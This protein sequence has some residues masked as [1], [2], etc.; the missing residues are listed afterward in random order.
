MHWTSRALLATLLLFQSITPARALW[1]SEFLADNQTGIRDAEGDRSDWLEIENPSAVAVSMDGWFLTDDANQ[2]QKWRF[3]A[4]TLA[5]GGRLLVFASGKDKRRP[6]FELHTNFQLSSNGEYLALV[7]PD[8]V[9]VEHAYAPSYPPQQPDISYGL[10]S[11]REPIILFSTNTPSFWKIPRAE[12]DRPLDWNQPGINLVSWNQGT[13]ALGFDTTPWTNA[14]GTN[15]ARGRSA[16]QSSTLSPFSAFLAVDGRLT[17]FTQTASGTGSNAYWEVTMASPFLIDSVVVRNRQDCCKSRLRDIQIS[18]RNTVGNVVVYESALLNPENILG[19]PDQITLELSEELLGRVAGNRIRITRVRDPDLSGGGVSGDD[20]EVLSM[21]EVEVYGRPFG[22]SLA[23]LIRTDLAASMS[24]AASSCLVRVPFDDPWKG[25]RTWEELRLKVRYNDGFVAYLNGVEVARL[26]APDDLAWNSAARTNRSKA[27][28]FNFD[29]LDLSP[30]A[31]L[32]RPTGNVL[33]FQALSSGLQDTE[34]ILQPVLQGTAARRDPGRYLQDPTP[35]T[36]NSSGSMGVTDLV[37]FSVERGF[38]T[39]PVDVVLSTTTDGAVIRY[40]LD[41]SDPEGEA[42]LVYT[43]PI[44]LTKTTP[45]RAISVKNG[46]RS[47]PSVTH[48]YFFLEDIVKQTPQTTLA[49]GFPTTWGGVTPDYGMDPRVIGGSTPDLFGGKYAA[50]IRDDLRSLPT[51]AL[52]VNVDDLFGANGIYSRSDAGGDAFE[53]DVSAEMIQTNGATAFQ[54]NAGLRVQGGAFRS[55]GL[56]KKH[57]LRLLFNGAHGPSKL[58]YPVFGPDA[59]N[60]FDTITLRAN[61]N[62][63]YSWGDAATQPLYIRDAFGRET[64]LEINGAASH[65]Q[66]VHLYL[67]SLYWGLYDM[68]ERPDSTFSAANFGGEREEWDSL[69]SGTPTEGDTRAW[70]ILNRLA[71]NTLVNNTNYFRLQGRDPDGTINSS[72]TNY[73]D[74]PNMIDYMIVNLWMGN[75]D[76]P[77]KNYWVGRR[78]VESTGYKFYMWDAEW[79]IGLRS[80]LSTDRTG[81]TEGVAAPYA[82]CRLNAEFRLLFGDHLQRHLLGD[83]ALAVD[84][85][86]PIWDPNNPTGNRPAAR[87]A[88]LAEEIRRGMVAESARWG[89]MHNLLPYTRDEQ[90]AVE[91]DLQLATYFPTRTEVVL[92]QFR[93]AG[94]FPAIDAPVFSLRSG[95]IE[96]GTMLQIGSGAGTVYYTTNGSDPRLIGG[97]PAPDAFAYTG[98]FPLPGRCKLKARLNSGNVWSALAEAVFT[99]PNPLPLRITEIHYHPPTEGSD[100]RFFTDDSQFIE[101]K[102]VG[103]SPLD[104]TGVKLTRGVRF[105]FTRS[106]VRILEPGAYVVL[107]KQREAFESHYGAVSGF[108]GVFEGALNHDNDRITL[109]SGFDEVIQDFRYS[110]SAFPTTD[111]LGYS[112]VIADERGGL[113]Q[114]DHHSGWRPSTAL[115]GSPGR[116]DPAP[117]I[118]HVRITEVMSRGLAGTPDMIELQNQESAAASI[119]GWFLTDDPK[120]PKK[121]RIPPGTTLAARGFVSYSDTQ[122]DPKPKSPAGFG[123]SSSGDEVWLFSADANGLLTGYADRL[124]FGPSAAGFTFIAW[125]ASDG[126]RYAVASTTPTLGK[127]NSNPLPATAI[128]SRVQRSVTPG[129]IDF[130]EIQNRTGAA[131]RLS[132]DG[133]PANSWRIPALAWSFPAGASLPPGGS[134]VLVS[135][136]P[137]LFRDRYQVPADVQILGPVEGLGSPSDFHLELQRPDTTLSPLQ[138]ITVDQWTLSDDP[139]WP[140][141][142]APAACLLRVKPELPG[143][144]PGAWVAGVAEPGRALPSGGTAPSILQQPEDRVVAE[145]QPVMFEVQAN[146][147]GTLHYVWRHN[148][149]VVPDATG[150]RLSLDATTAADAGVYEVQVLSPNGAA[151]SRSAFLTDPQAPPI[152]TLP[153]TRVVL[154]STPTTFHVSASG[155]GNL[156]YQWLFEGKPLVGQTSNSLTLVAIQP[157]QG[158]RYQLSISDQIGT[159]ISPPIVLQVATR[160]AV[161]EQPQSLTVT[162]GGTAQFRV[163][164]SGTTPV[165]Y[166]WRRNGSPLSNGIFYLDSNTSI[167]QLTNVQLAQAGRFTVV[168]TNPAPVVAVTSLEAVLTVLADADRDGMPDAWEKSYGFNS[169]FAGDALQDADGDGYSN[170][171]EYEAGTDPRSAQS[172]LQIDNITF[173]ETSCTISWLAVSN[174]TYTLLGRRTLEEESWVPLTQSFNRPT[175]RVE[176]FVDPINSGS[177]RYYRLI[178]PA[179]F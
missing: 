56:T 124:K 33:A 136:D 112:L 137:E 15:I 37:T 153:A 17:N 135:I 131:L 154:A 69:N 42:A 139:S 71:N 91:R 28:G 98:P 75:S 149:V 52:T 96:P 89:D 81:V 53:R 22:T 179:Q 162:E 1:I 6:D 62:D 48:S 97:K 40:T 111:G 116:Q 38:Y 147:N 90:W 39:D 14:P 59:P 41:G 8:G 51:L 167:L 12:T 54:I 63:G 138:F 88:R 117:S 94:L 55:D 19:G 45:L 20:A 66:F 114:W 134:C 118:P 61:S 120:T 121:F 163:V 93:S 46:W 32:V 76:W 4:V 35:G 176:R 79:S 151:T 34:F 107:A 21:S 127:A 159:T 36:S 3:P 146:G 60:Q 130:I 74:V 132:Q 31:A 73:L 133:A 92:Q 95:M 110:A 143:I 178:T 85:A 129:G 43:Q 177:S 175:N 166:R 106:A 100:S 29:T 26:N 113:D 47:S 155:I 9:T 156:S 30:F 83:G 144:E 165:Y 5:P 158:G 104:L 78:R 164:V 157:A 115:G 128:F 174:R 25:E 102:N 2:L 108:A 109:V 10:A 86:H 101:L 160:L 27:L 13:L 18:V 49:S 87:F 150:S 77:Q 170:R 84:P 168:M 24:G 140:K 7:R 99:E 103:N 161:L 67:N 64:L 171:A 70:D 80:D 65:H 105:D 173:D 142:S 82:A 122:F 68:V 50:T 58:R 145:Q 148:G 16:I 72:L 11:Q 23:P 125:D 123:L 172:K 126:E 57:S 141:A 44:H 169:A 152:T 119:G